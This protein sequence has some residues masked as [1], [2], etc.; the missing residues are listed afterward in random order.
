MKTC[1]LATVLVLAVAS[2]GWTVSAVVNKAG[3]GGAFTTIQAAIDSG[4]D[5]ITIT[6][7]GVYEENLEIGDPV[8]G[9]TAVTLTSTQSG[10]SRPVITPTTEVKQYSSVERDN[11]A[12]GFGLF[13]NGSVI[14]NLI[15]EGHPDVGPMGGLFVMANDVLIENCL[16]RP[17][18]GTTQRIGFPN[19]LLMFAQEG[20]PATKIPVPGGRN[21]DGCIVRDCELTGLPTD[22]VVEPTADDL[23]YLEQAATT[24]RADGLIRMFYQPTDDV[25][26]VTF[27]N[28]FFHHSRDLGFL[29]RYSGVGGAG[30][31]NI[32]VNRCRFDAFYKFA[33]GSEGANLFVENSIFTRSNQGKSEDAERSAINIKT[34]DGHTPYGEVTNCLF[35]NC[36][37]AW[38]QRGYYGGVVNYSAGTLNVDHCTFVK[39]LSGV[40]VAPD[41]STGGASE[42]TQMTV[43]N[44]IFHQIGYNGVE[45]LPTVDEDSLPITDANT[46]VVNGLFPAW[47]LGLTNF[48]RGHL[49]SAAFNHFDFHASLDDDSRLIVDNCLVGDIASEDSRAW[50]TVLAGG[51]DVADNV[52]GS[53]LTTGEVESLDSVTRGTP[54]FLNT[55]PDADNPFDLA[56]GSPG[57]GLGFSAVSGVG[58]WDL[59]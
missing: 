50:D 10:D 25:I 59:Y 7:S 39:C 33:L 6:D 4:A 40:T 43:S 16:F 9:G 27:E 3:T 35:V 37:G 12:Y 51:I 46:N 57:Q 1:L 34:R 56:P 38:A 18:A 48:V 2:T 36:G 15:I 31:L 28:C 58:E 29:P 45:S 47:R 23:G 14:S 55:D 32:Q 8:S 20:D 53:R 49:W 26:T 21:C 30:E 42:N 41:G 24:G 52:L 54:I 17:R 11:F 44:S 5:A 19:T 22:A 13:A